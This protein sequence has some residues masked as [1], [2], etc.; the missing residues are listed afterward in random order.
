[1]GKG[2]ET[3][4][5]KAKAAERAG[6][7]DAA[8]RIYAA[9]LNG[10]P[11]N[12]R[13]RA[14]LARLE[15]SAAAKA[16]TDPLAALVL[17]YRQGRFDELVAAGTP[18]LASHPGSRPLLDLLGNAHA[19][20]KRFAEAEAL[21]QRSTAIDPGRPDIFRNL[22]IVLRAQGKVAE[23]LDAWD[24][25]LALQPD[26]GAVHLARARLLLDMGRAQDSIAA[27]QRV[28]ALDPDH[29]EALTG[30]GMAFRARGEWTDAVE[31]L[32]RAVAHRPDHAG[33]R[34][35]L[36][37]ALREL[38]RADE[39]IEQCR[40]AVAIDP[41]DASA[42]EGL[43]ALYRDRKQLDLAVDSLSAVLAV[44]PHH[45]RARAQKLH[46]E[47][48]MCDW[49][50]IEAFRAIS[51]RIGTGQSPV[52]PFA[53]LACEDNPDHQLRRAERWATHAFPNRAPPIPARPRAA[54]SPIRVGYFS[55]DFHDHA[56][57]L[58]TAGLFRE[59]DLRRFDISIYSFGHQR[60]GLLRRKLTA[61]VTHFHDVAHLGDADLTAL[62]R[63]HDLDI[64]IDLKGYTTDSRTGLFSR[65]L[66]PIQI[67][68]LAYPG[69]MGADFIDYMVA[70]PIV[71]PATERAYYR[72]KLIVLPHSYLANDN[73]REIPR[74]LSSR[75][76]VGL[77]AQ[78]LV[79]CCFNN[80][81]KIGPAEFDIWMRVL[82]Q[83]EG[84]VLWLLKGNDWAVTN[85][86]REAEKHGIDPDRLVF[87]PPVSQSEHL[88]RL[89][90]A[91]LVLDTFHY[92]AHTTG[93]DALWSGVPLV[94]MVG[95]QFAARVAASLLHAVGLPELVTGT[96]DDYEALILDLVRQPGR[97]AA[98]RAKLADNRLTAPLFDT[99]LYTRHLEAA[100]EIAWARKQRGEPAADIRVG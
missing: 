73:R 56:T 67:N 44:A 76:D 77:P 3:S 6:D 96:T 52:L 28:L 35:A 22:G 8:R 50:G 7:P 18:L 53:M 95:R 17:L 36:G 45:D 68:Y 87:A 51:D 49:S 34:L 30:L 13:A 100:Y 1:M 60:S 74:P 98:I 85:L 84:S 58:L 65:R 4:F 47:A 94:T 19:A 38:G 81:Y 89:V 41:G 15:G 80:S 93:C 27:F 10:F 32:T 83:A 70:D 61:D 25:A 23:A 33:L 72:E 71:I 82:A 62:A 86:R 46:L 9:I 92:N 24:R 91:D 59:H 2:L 79:F 78:G 14:A 43:A 29:V 69:S 97:L 90:H 88:A 66:A 37:S 31:T 57:L 55:A 12:A 39:A 16:G 11:G 42:H 20:T 54:D 5:V 63:G 21:F 40:Q 64:A 26:L 99:P 75:S 48:H